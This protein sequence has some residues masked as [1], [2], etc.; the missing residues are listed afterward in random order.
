MKL[1]FAYIFVALGIENNTVSQI[2]DQ[3][4]V[5]DRKEK[6][7]FLSPFYPTEIVIKCSKKY[8]KVIVP[9]AD[10][11]VF[12]K[13]SLLSSSF[14]GVISFRTSKDNIVRFFYNCPLGTDFFQNDEIS[15]FDFAETVL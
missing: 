2:S 1:T 11:R 4:M 10:N 13:A 6:N 8:I 5:Y 12:L 3:T 14:P 15:A 7:G 9:G